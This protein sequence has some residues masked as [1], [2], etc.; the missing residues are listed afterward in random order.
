MIFKRAIFLA[1]LL[2][3]TSN[4]VS[5]AD[6]LMGRYD[7]EQR[8]NSAEK[9]TL[10]IAL[11]W[12]YT[13]NKFDNN[14]A[15]PVVSGST[16]FFASGDRVYAID[17][18]T[19]NLKW[20]YPADQPLGGQVRGT[21]AIYDGKVYFGSGDGNLYCVDGDTGTFQWA[22]QTRGSVRCPPVILNGKVY[23]GSDDNSIY[24]VD[25]ETG[26][27]GWAKPFTAKDDFAVGLAVGNDMIVGACM[28]GNVYGISISGRLRWAYR[29]PLAPLNTSPILIESVAAM[30]VGNMIYGISTRGGQLRWTI[31]L[32]AEAAATPAS[33][34]AT[35]YIPCR[36]KKIYAYTLTGRKPTIKW[37][38][39]ADLG[40]NPLSS[41]VIA[42]VP[43]VDS[44]G[45][46]D[47]ESVLF[48]TGGKGIIACYSA[49]SG[50]LKWRYMIAPSPTFGAA[51]TDAASSPTV[52][53]GTLTVVTDDGVLHC[54]SPNAPDNEAPVAYDYKPAN[55]SVIPAA[56]PIKLSAVIYDIGS[57]VD[58]S[59]VTM[60]LDGQSVD[61]K[62]DFSTS[63]ITCTIEATAG[64]K[65]AKRLSDG[66]HTI[67]VT[68]KDY[69]GNLLNQDWLVYADS[70]LQPPK[71]ALTEDAGK[72]AKEPPRNPNSR[73][74]PNSRGRGYNRSTSPGAGGDTPPPPPSPPGGPPFMPSPPTRGAAPV[75]DG[76]DVADAN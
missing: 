28:D 16:C 76:P 13:A 5:V 53:N 40:T 41:P 44:E 42:S 34:G 45:K 26:D 10:P 24:A 4:T 75:P 65:A 50:S 71:R 51:Y 66:I 32:P 46:P 48:V 57:G 19:G 9:I 38:Q 55:A 7:P 62:T 6:C 43:G 68:A 67:A 1:A 56:P 21:P 2:V 3:I 70:R 12:E 29:L 61:F 52:A 39:P 18:E 54:F 11:N 22:Y 8:S 47:E 73:Y 64:N 49:D 60:T 30:A 58:F 36:D 20:K 59:T 69:A 37:T 14:P 31:S 74:N 33:D 63:T 15:S 35:I 72:R 23:F 17:L 27:L 25:A